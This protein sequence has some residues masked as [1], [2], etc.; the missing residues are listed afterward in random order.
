MSNRKIKKV[1]GALR[2][3]TKSVNLDPSPANYKSWEG[4]IE[5]ASQSGSRN[6]VIW[7]TCGVVA[8]LLFSC[9]WSAVQPFYRRDVQGGTTQTSY[10]NVYVE[11][12]TATSRPTAFISCS[13]IS[14][15]SL[16]KTP[17][18][19]SKNDNED[20]IIAVQCGQNVELMGPTRNV[21]GLRWWAV[22]W[23]GYYGWMA[24]HTS[25]GKLILVFR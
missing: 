2:E 1:L 4:K 11:Q 18:Y 23:N 20:V 10:Q 13:E 25:S 22:G 8:L 16:R 14:M 5:A 7:F 17:G 15:V 6:L 3:G 12:P 24:D 19:L 9:I 21:D